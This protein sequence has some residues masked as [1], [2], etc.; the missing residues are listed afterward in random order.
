MHRRHKSYLLVFLVL[1]L[2]P[3]G[4]FRQRF[5][6]ASHFDIRTKA[7]TTLH[8]SKER[9]LIS[10]TASFRRANDIILLLAETRKYP[11]LPYNA[12]TGGR[13]AEPAPGERLS[14]GG[15]EGGP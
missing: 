2:L 10:S 4:A 5:R 8:P 13:E 11:S 14:L 6:P 1:L 9:S 15:A 3:L 7:K 12:V